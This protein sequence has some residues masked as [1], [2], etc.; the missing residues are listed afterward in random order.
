MILS[1]FFLLLLST[2]MVSAS[3]PSILD[4]V[5][6]FFLL[7]QL[8]CSKWITFFTQ[9]ASL[10]HPNFPLGVHGSK[11]LL[12][13]CEIVQNATNNT[14]LQVFRADGIPILTKADNVAMVLIPYIYSAALNGENKPNFVNSGFEMLT[15]VEQ[16]ESLLIANVTEL[17]NRN[18]LQ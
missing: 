15:I 4:V 17:F 9:D 12:N 18:L 11:E 8:P 3:S 1:C 2:P 16:S 7:F 6:N 14:S 10:Y 13:F 5:S